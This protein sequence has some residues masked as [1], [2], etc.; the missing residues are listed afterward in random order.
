M[1]ERTDPIKVGDEV[2]VWDCLDLS[3]KQGVV[4][5]VRELGIDYTYTA[6][7]KE[8]WSTAYRGT[9]DRT[10]SSYSDCFLAEEQY[11]L[12]ELLEREQE[13]VQ[14]R[15]AKMMQDAIS[16]ANEY[17]ESQAHELVPA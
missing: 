12:A 5:K 15:L 11:Q 6:D 7:G 14:R 9:Y 1:S 13:L 17:E 10:I 8:K 4:S 3:V 16:R 2:W